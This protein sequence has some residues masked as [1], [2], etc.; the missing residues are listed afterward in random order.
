MHHGEALV[1]RPVETSAPPP[2]AEDAARPRKVCWNCGT[3]SPNETSRDCADCME[4]LI[5]P[6]LVIA[7]PAGRVVVSACGQSVDLGRAGQFSRVFDRYPNVSRWHATVS[8]DADGDA[9]L[10][11]NPAAP[12]GTFLNDK[13]IM[14]RTPLRPGDRIRFATC[15]GPNIGPTSEPVRQPRREPAPGPGG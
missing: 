7:F 9:W 11:P 2:A 14:D 4:S 15:E 12:N 6:T 5:P 8:V 10:A 13:E 3:T 1:P